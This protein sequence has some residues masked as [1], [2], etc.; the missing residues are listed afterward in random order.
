MYSNFQVQIGLISLD[1]DYNT[2]LLFI[3]SHNKCKITAKR[4]VYLSY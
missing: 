2:L 4:L 1:L 3:G